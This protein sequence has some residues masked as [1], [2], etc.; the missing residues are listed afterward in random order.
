MPISPGSSG[1]PVLNM[2]GEVIGVATLQ[3]VEGQNL[4]FAITA[5]RITKV[6]SGKGK[7]L[8]GREEDKAKEFYS[9]GLSFLWVGDYEKA[10]PC[11]EK[12]AKENPGD[13]DAYVLIGYCDGN[14]GRYQEAIEAYKQTI[15]IK[16][17]FALAHKKLGM[18][19]LANGNKMLP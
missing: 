5:D 11:F 1:S 6:K 19:Y 12:A 14:L 13:A 18:A 16:P 8:E 2:K 4:N 7:P 10:L 9:K 17:D 15:R 3:M